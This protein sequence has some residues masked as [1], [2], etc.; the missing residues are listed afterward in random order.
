MTNLSI[1]SMM[2]IILYYGTQLVSQDKMSPGDLMAYMYA[3]QSSLKSFSTVGVLFGQVIKSFGSGCRIFEYMDLKPNILNGSMIPNS[4]QGHVEFKQVD[5]TYPTR[6]NDP[7]LN[8]FTLEL[9]IGKVVALCGP[10]G[11]GKST[12][13]QLLERFYDIKNGS[14]LLDGLDITK[15]DSSWL[16]RNIGYI[17]QEPILF[18]GTIFDNIKYGN[19]NATLEEVQEA[20]NQA[21]AS[22]FIENFPNKYNTRIGER[23]VTLSGGQKQ[24]IAIARALLKN[25]RILICD[26]ATSALDTTSERIVQEALSRL[27]KGRTVLVIAHRLSTIQNADMIVV[28]SRKGIVEMGSHD[29]LLK[30]RG[31]YYEFYKKED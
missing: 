28:M 17:D 26:E 7:I 30:K 4:L 29:D 16:R 15:L 3:T 2:L 5:F 6:P 23:G 13:G 31:A 25:P 1:G 27:M 14:I 20:A 21:N 11:S 24:R 19:P 22:D 10:S 8:S 18:A 12:V 9:P